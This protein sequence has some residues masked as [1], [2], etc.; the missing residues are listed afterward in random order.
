VSFNKLPHNVN[1]LHI[2][3]PPHIYSFHNSHR[4]SRSPRSKPSFCRCSIVGVAGST[5]TGWHGCVPLVIVV[6][7][8]VEGCAADRSL[9]QRRHIERV[10]YNYDTFHVNVLL[11]TRV[12]I[13]NYYSN[14]LA[15]YTD[16][17]RAP[18]YQAERC[19]QSVILK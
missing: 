18:L 6:C 15:Q 5:T 7:C 12:I 8:E 11:V 14:H 16:C 9:V 10:F 2:I 3:P 19:C 13:S 1:T 4:R 17:Q